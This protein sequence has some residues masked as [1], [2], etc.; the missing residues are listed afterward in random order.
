M[1]ERGPTPADEALRSQQ[2]LDALG[3]APEPES[4]LS[5]AEVVLATPIANDPKPLA[6]RLGELAGERG[7]RLGRIL[8]ALC[9][10]APFFTPALR[11]HPEWILSL[12]E[13]DLGQP[14]R[15][16]D[17]ARRLRDELAAAGSDSPAS[18]LRRFK[19][20]ELARLTIRDCCEQWVPL[21]Q[22]A[23]TLAEVSQLA[24]V[25]L[26]RALQTR[27]RL[28]VRAIRPASLGHSGW[29]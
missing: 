14:R 1:S 23:V 29:R 27:R 6:A 13:E 5:R 28:R 18:V 3:R 11:R 12:L 7:Q 9:G 8:Y 19:Y 16:D 15:R 2:I 20:Y 17:L 21:S 25:L 10:V 24:D 26:D 22:S 4:T